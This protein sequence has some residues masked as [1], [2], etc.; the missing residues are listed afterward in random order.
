MLVLEGAARAATAPALRTASWAAPLVTA[1][2]APGSGDD[3]VVEQAQDAAAT[4]AQVLVVTSDRALR[5]R[6]TAAVPH[7]VLAGPRTLTALLDPPVPS[8]EG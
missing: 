5:D 6:V 2:A 4:G 1:V 8:A 3:A 7:A